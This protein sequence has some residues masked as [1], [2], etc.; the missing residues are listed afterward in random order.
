MYPLAVLHLAGGPQPRP[1]RRAGGHRRSRVLRRGRPAAAHHAERGQPAHPRPRGRGRPGPD[2]PGHAVPAY[3]ARRVAGP[4]RPADPAAVRRGGPGAH[5]GRPRSSC[6]WRS[7]PTRWRS[8]SATCSPRS[9]RGTG[10]AI[11][12]HVEDQAYSQELLRS[13]DVLAAVTSDPAAGAGLH[14]RPLGALRYLPAAAPAFADRWRRGR[15]PRLGGDAGRRLQR[16]G[17]PAARPAAPAGRRAAAA[18]RPPGPVH[19]RLLPAVRLGLGWGMLPEPQAGADLAA[20]GSS[21]C[22]R[23]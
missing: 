7:T 6:R 2:Q 3:P 22:R 13:G 10:T 21:C 11:R 4:A 16:Q 9:R 14:R 1:A 20:G 19:R 8:G 17:R 15:L 5:G 18:G 12:L 23:T